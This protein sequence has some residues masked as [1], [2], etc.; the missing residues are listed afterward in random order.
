MEQITD[1]I[2]QISNQINAIQQ[3]LKKPSKEWTEEEKEEYGS[4]EQL[5]EERKQLRKKEQ[6]REERRA[7]QRQRARASKAKNYII[8]ERPK[9]RFCS[10]GYQPS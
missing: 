7:A 8:A 2:K 1:E 4:K 5:R 6:L 3:M 9:S 10:K